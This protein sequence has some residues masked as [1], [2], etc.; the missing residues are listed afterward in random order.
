VCVHYIERAL[1]ESGGVKKKT[2][3]LLGLKSPQVLTTWMEK[4]GINQA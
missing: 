2:A 4:Y 3:Q 1:L